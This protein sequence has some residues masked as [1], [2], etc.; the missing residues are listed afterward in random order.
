MRKG[1]IYYLL[2]YASCLIFAAVK[3]SAYITTKNTTDLILAL[4][5]IALMLGYALRSISMIFKKDKSETSDI[6]IVVL[7]FVLLAINLF[8]PNIIG[9]FA[10]QTTA[11]K[12]YASM[13][14]F[15]RPTSYYR[16][17]EADDFNKL[18]QQLLDNNWSNFRL[19]NKVI[20]GNSTVR[21]VSTFEDNI[22]VEY[23]DRFNTTVRFIQ[24]RKGITT[25]N[26]QFAKL[27]EKETIADTVTEEI[28]IGSYT[29]V[30]EKIKICSDASE[31]GYRTV[32]CYSWKTGNYSYFIET[33]C[34]MEKDFDEMQAMIESMQ[35]INVSETP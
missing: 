9:I 6:R 3:I 30:E 31:N 32:Y 26:K 1:I 21:S 23:G 34:D 22:T 4:V 35:N 12:D 27:V 19:P 7:G 14:N 10:E 5:F 13:L 24:N 15:G 8:M 2:F 18:Y 11:E 16:H 29:V 20:S 17:I 25:S 28:Q 33:T